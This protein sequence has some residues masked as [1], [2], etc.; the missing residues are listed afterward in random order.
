MHLTQEE[1]MMMANA[2]WPYRTELL[3]NKQRFLEIEWC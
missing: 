2:F 1:E 3:G